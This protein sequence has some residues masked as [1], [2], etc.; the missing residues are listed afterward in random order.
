MHTRTP[1][2]HAQTY[3]TWTHIYNIATHIR[4]FALNNPTF[5]TVAGKQKHLSAALKRSTNDIFL[6]F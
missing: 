1:K 2:F 6:R 4:D 5:G 3:A